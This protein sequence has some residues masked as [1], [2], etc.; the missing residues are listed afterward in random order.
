MNV[1]VYKLELYSAISREILFIPYYANFLKTFSSLVK[2]DNITSETSTLIYTHYMSKYPFNINLTTI[3]DIDDTIFNKLLHN[4]SKLELYG[5]KYPE[6]KQLLLHMCNR[7]KQFPSH[8]T[9][10][11]DHII[12]YLKNPTLI[13]T[14][15]PT[16]ITTTSTNVETKTETTTTNTTLKNAGKI[17]RYTKH[18]TDYIFVTLPDNYEYTY[19][20][21]LSVLDISEKEISEYEREKRCISYRVFMKQLLKFVKDEQI[22]SGCNIIFDSHS[23]RQ[24][25]ISNLFTSSTFDLRSIEQYIHVISS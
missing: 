16:T 24:D 21:I 1:E 19:N 12:T 11:I 7:C 3:H 17:K 23:Q 18:G 2:N 20:D 8:K 13:T 22:Q 10:D 14:S 15:L 25:V 4:V 6:Y 5:S 9:Y